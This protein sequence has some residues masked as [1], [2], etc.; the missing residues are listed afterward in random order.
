M[1]IKYKT[2]LIIIVSIIG[3]GTVSFYQ[4]FQFNDG[5]LH[6][7][8][9]NVGQG[10]SIF[11]RTPKGKNILVDSGPPNGKVLECLS[12]HM[13]FWER[14]IDIVSLT[15]FHLDHYGG[16][17]DVL[18]RYVV[19]YFVAKN[20]RENKVLQKIEKKLENTNTKL[21]LLSVK[22][23]IKTND[24][25][26]ILVIPPF[27]F[28]RNLENSDNTELDSNV[29][30]LTFKNFKL[31]LTGDSQTL[32][33]DEVINK[34]NIEKIN[35]LQIPHHGS[36]TG[37]DKK[38]LESL[39]FNLSVISVGEGNKYGHPSKEVLKL[40]ESIGKEILRTDKNG[41]IEIVSDGDKYYIKTQFKR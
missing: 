28:N 14:N 17:E 2:I 27:L 13:P 20:N 18:K 16:F 23:T 30:L 6:V 22:T 36:K 7:V 12:S 25:V 15:H 8:F 11:V 40:L 3:L 38:I 31:L 19:M 26:E 5:K 21:N 35:V 1:K 10:D 9:C 39:D 41:E 32:T 34:N 29:H 33:L 4:Y 37:V 24:N